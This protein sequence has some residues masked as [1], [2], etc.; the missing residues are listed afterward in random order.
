MITACKFSDEWKADGKPLYT[1]SRELE[2]SDESIVGPD[3][4]RGE[5]GAMHIDWVVRKIVGMTL[6]Y[7][8]MTEPELK[9]MMDLIKGK[10]F[11]F[12]YPDPQDGLRTVPA[13]CSKVNYARY[14]DALG[15]RIYTNVSFPIAE[16]EG[17]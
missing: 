13:Y 8:T 5:N 1:P 3:S 2:C 6:V 15:V 14:S 12:T 10:E 11:M 9:Y 4:G 17:E 7:K 16:M